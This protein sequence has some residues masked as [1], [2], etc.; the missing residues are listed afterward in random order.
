MAMYHFA[1]EFIK[2]KVVLDAG[3][4]FDTVRII[5]PIMRKTRSAWIIVPRLSSGQ[6]KHYVKKQSCI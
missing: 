3:C 5:L 6:K 1:G 4:A 2:Q